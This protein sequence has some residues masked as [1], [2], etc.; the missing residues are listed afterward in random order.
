MIASVHPPP[1]LNSTSTRGCADGA[2]GRADA[3]SPDAK[4]NNATSTKGAVFVIVN[5]SS[6]RLTAS[7]AR[8]GR[9]LTENEPLGG[10]RYEAGVSSGTLT[11]LRP[12]RFAGFPE[13]LKVQTVRTGLWPQFT[14]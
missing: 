5:G 14:N 12:Q 4:A 2:A 6:G 10:I 9:G 3:V 1:G 8:P 13:C 11:P 7:S